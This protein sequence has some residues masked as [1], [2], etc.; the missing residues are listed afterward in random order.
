MLYY[1]WSACS[2][3]I[4][5]NCYASINIERGRHC[6]LTIFERPAW[7]HNPKPS[8]MSWFP[9]NY[10]VNYL[11]KIL[12]ISLIVYASMYV[13]FFNGGK[14]PYMR[15]EM[16]MSLRNKIYEAIMINRFLQK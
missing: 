16:S 15:Y 10:P 13:D 2:E 9:K 7:G 1:L 5:N 8:H 11:F 12:K 4:E 6:L 14:F 3:F